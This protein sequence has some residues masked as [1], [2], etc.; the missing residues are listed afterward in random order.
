M[1]VSTA[2]VEQ[3]NVTAIRVGAR[4]RKSLGSLA[5][6]KGS[7]EEHGLIHPIL[8]RGDNELVAGNRR[9]AACTALGWKSIPA[10]RVDRMSDDELRAI[11]LEENTERLDLSAAERSRQRLAEMRQEEAD[12][13]NKPESIRQKSRGRPSTTSRAAKTVGVTDDTVRN[14]KA[15]VTYA[16]RYPFME[17]WSRQQHV[18]IL[19]GC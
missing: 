1:S 9:L 4:R 16:E 14:D 11:E 13:A 3:V 6:L 15:T 12:E 2:D 18:R 10:R 7:I 19:Q 17:G 5:G 8:L